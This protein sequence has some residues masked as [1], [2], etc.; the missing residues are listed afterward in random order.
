[1]TV[2]WMGCRAELMIAVPASFMLAGLLASHSRLFI[3][4]MQVSDKQFS[5]LLETQLIG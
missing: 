4:C 1:M 3:S 5:R 2:S